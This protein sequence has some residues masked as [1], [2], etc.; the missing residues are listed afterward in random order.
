MDI[1]EVEQRVMEVALNRRRP[2]DLPDVGDVIAAVVAQ[3]SGSKTARQTDRLFTAAIRTQADLADL[4]RSRQRE[5]DLAEALDCGDRL[6]TLLESL[7]GDPH[8]PHIKLATADAE[9][10]TWNA[11]LARL[12]G[13]AA[14]HL[15]AAA[16][17]SWEDAA[18]PP[19]QAYCLWRQ[20]DLLLWNG[21]PG[22]VAALL[23]RAADAAAQTVPLLTFITDLARRARIRIDDGAAAPTAGAAQ[24]TRRASAPYGLTERELGVLRLLGHGHTNKEIG[25]ELFISTKTASVH[26]TNILRK[27]GVGN[28]VQAATIAERAGILDE[29]P[30][31][32]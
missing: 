20:A 27:L 15:W 6:V 14:P 16:A 4:A 26:V 30:R 1:I 9:L 28:R 29:G 23:R 13:A 24:P 2:E 19:R 12:R 22:E 25:A 7:P 8:D 3:L 5:K 31:N 10:A 32:R 11:E 17:K 18:R 21:Q